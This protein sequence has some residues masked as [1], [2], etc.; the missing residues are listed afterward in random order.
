MIYTTVKKVKPFKLKTLDQEISLITKAQSGCSS[1]WNEL[2]TNNVK[3]VINVANKFSQSKEDLDDLVGE[4]IL[5]LHEAVKKFDIKKKNKFATYARSWV[6]N[7]ISDFVRTNTKSVYFPSYLINAAVTVGKYQK[8]Y[9]KKHGENPSVA[10]LKKKFGYSTQT[11]TRILSFFHIEESLNEVKGDNEEQTLLNIIDG[12]HK[13]ESD[14]FAHKI[15]DLISP[16]AKEML[17]LNCGIIHNK[18]ISYKQLGLKYNKSTQEIKKIIQ[19]SKKILSK[20]LKNK[21][22]FYNS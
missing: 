17:E 15:L 8:E 5:G 6:Y 22:L 13:D 4:G 10:H 19:D 16:E 14:G 11:V 3:L 1:S 21:K 18:R 9:F 2:I 12:E 7:K 20:A